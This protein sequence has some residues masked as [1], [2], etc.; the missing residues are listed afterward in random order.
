MGLDSTE[1]RDLSISMPGFRAIPCGKDVGDVDEALRAASRPNIKAYYCVYHQGVH[2]AESRIGKH[3]QMIEPKIQLRRYE[4]V[5]E[6]KR[7]VQSGVAE[8]FAIEKPVR[9]DQR[10]DKPRQHR[11]EPCA[12]KTH[13]GSKSLL[14]DS[15]ACSQ[16]RCA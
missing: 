6:G 10:L 2:L 3:A 16:S 8:R 11:T 1:V 14:S 12:Q 9:P 7:S 5:F 13:R 15:P 4:K